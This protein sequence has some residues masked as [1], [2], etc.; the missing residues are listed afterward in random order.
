MRINNL[1]ISEDQISDCASVKR[2]NSVC[3]EVRKSIGAIIKFRSIYP[4]AYC[5]DFLAVIEDS[6][7]QIR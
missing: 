6:S 5:L 3:L 7:S 4:A 2:P 1:A